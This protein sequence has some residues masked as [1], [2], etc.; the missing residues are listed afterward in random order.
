MT[1]EENKALVRRYVNAQNRGDMEGMLACFA[2]D[3]VN[4]AGRLF[5]ACA[6]LQIHLFVYQ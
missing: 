5:S 6:V 1:V 3:V 2:P 4:H